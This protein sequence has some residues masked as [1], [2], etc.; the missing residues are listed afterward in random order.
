MPSLHLILTVKF[1][2]LFVALISNLL[3]ALY[4][5][6]K[7]VNLLLPPPLPFLYLI[8]AIIAI[9]TPAAIKL[10]TMQ[11][12]EKDL[13]LNLLLLHCLHHGLSLSFS[14]HL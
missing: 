3:K 9:A 1:K 11:Q 13:S 8:L 4:T 12:H 10:T 5:I 7:T 2:L 14:G 6:A